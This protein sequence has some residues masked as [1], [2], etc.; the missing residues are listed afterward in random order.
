MLTFLCVVALLVS[1]A[2]L[3]IAVWTMSIVNAAHR[4]QVKF[5]DR[6]AEQERNF[7]R[8]MEATVTFQKV[9]IEHQS[10]TDETLRMHRTA[11]T[12][13]MDATEPSADTLLIDITPIKI[14]EPN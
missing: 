12:T 14:E 13:L 10:I 2:A 9:T 8:F 5:N 4:N 1:L 11:L 3:G 7:I 6:V